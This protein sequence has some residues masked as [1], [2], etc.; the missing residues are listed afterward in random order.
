MKD[1][2][3]WVSDMAGTI[4]DPND[5]IKPTTKTH[6]EWSVRIAMAD[7]LHPTLETAAD[8]EDWLEVFCLGPQM[9]YDLNILDRLEEGL[10]EHWVQTSSESFI[11]QIIFHRRIRRLEKKHG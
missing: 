7:L 11:E 8:Y 10:K 5:F 3:A 9:I 6:S 1:F 4:E 2:G